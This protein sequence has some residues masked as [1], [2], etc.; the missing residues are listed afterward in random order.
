MFGSLS[1]TEIF[2]IMVLALLIFGPKRLPEIG[3][4]IGKAIGEFRRASSD[5]KRSVE[6]E[7]S[8]D[9]ER[10]AERPSRPQAPRLGA[11]RE[12]AADETG[13]PVSRGSLQDRDEERTS[14]EA[15]SPAD[16]PDAVSAETPDRSA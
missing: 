4:T 7:L 12:A 5:F 14:E 16:A 15:E 2:F 1:F 8:M 3:R 10:A 11:A 6:V 13:E 9:E